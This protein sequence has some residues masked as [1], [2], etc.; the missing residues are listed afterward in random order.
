MRLKSRKITSVILFWLCISL[1]GA[2]S[3]KSSANERMQKRIDSVKVILN[4]RMLKVSDS[5]IV[6]KRRALLSNRNN[7][8]TKTKLSKTDSVYRTMYQWVAEKQT[9]YLRRKGDSIKFLNKTKR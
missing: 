1:A 7:G 3:L 4:G 8:F 9:Q 6:S 5:A 2:Q